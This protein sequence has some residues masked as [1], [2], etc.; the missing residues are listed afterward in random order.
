[1]CDRKVDQDVFTTNF[2]ENF[3]LVFNIIFVLSF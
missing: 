1:M 3:H 2:R